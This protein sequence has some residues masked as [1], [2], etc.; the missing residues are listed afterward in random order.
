[1]GVFP[2]GTGQGALPA[3]LPHARGG[4]SIQPVRREEDRGAVGGR[5]WLAGDWGDKRATVQAGR[6]WTIR[7]TVH[8]ARLASDPPPGKSP[9]SPGSAGTGRPAPLSSS[10]RTGGSRTQSQL[11]TDQFPLAD[12]QRTHQIK[13]KPLQHLQKHGKYVRLTPYEHLSRTYPVQLADTCNR[14][15]A[16]ARNRIVRCP[17][18]SP[19]CL[20]GPATTSDRLPS[21]ALRGS[22]ATSL[23]PQFRHPRFLS[24][25][26]PGFAQDRYHHD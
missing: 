18:A 16:S 20:V 12:S 1:M 10:R 13:P 6:L 2:G 23:K 3:S 15:C 11:K 25:R 9:S 17:C 4:V 5:R 26:D 21:L 8:P 24:V 22:S 14:V 7:G 19:R